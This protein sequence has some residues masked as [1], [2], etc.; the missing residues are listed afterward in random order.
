MRRHLLVLAA[1]VAASGLPAQSMPAAAAGATTGPLAEGDRVRVT[2]ELPAGH[3]LSR[4]E[5]V[6]GVLRR[7]DADSVLLVEHGSLVSIPRSGVGSMSV[8][9]GQRSRGSLLARGAGLGFA[10]GAVAGGAIA[11]LAYEDC[12]GE[13]LCFTR[14]EETMMG[15]VLLGGTGTIVGFIVGAFRSGEE[16]R[17]VPLHSELHVGLAMTRHGPALALRF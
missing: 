1:L 14:G 10:G 17:R 7:I 6:T 12:S 16:W 4:R 3:P 13:F 9:V 11:Y 15:A 5:S 2:I 8:L